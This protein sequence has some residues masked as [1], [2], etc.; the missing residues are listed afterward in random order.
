MCASGNTPGMYLVTGAKGTIGSEVVRALV[1]AGEPVRAL[2]RDGCPEGLPFGVDVQHGDL[3]NPSSL[4]AAFIGVKGIFVLPGHPGVA[5]AAAQSGITTVVQLSGTAVQTGDRANPISALMMESEDEVRETAARW[6]ILRPYD[7]MANT[8]RWQ[9]QLAGGDVVREAFAEVP[10]AM[11]DPYDVAAAA[12]LA[13]TSDSIQG[14]VFTLSGPE[15]VLPADRVRIL[16]ELLG[17]PLSLEPLT[18]NEAR[19][20]LSLQQP[21]EYV[22]AMFDFYVNGAL[23]VSHVLPTVE[24]LLGRP[25][26]TFREWAEAHLDAFSPA[27]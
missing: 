19:T 20:V 3:G 1:D 24:Q 6:T 26:R 8:L 23:D 17:R 15:P 25:G 10:V 7:F 21:P 18:D 4:A 9:P 16:G 14:E 12:A 13:L 5:A 11:I 22:D 2:T 27:A